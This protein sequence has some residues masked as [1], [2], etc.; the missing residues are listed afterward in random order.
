M[1]GHCIDIGREYTDVWR[2]RRV[3]ES[4]PCPPLGAW[5][6]CLICL[7]A[8]SPALPLLLPRLLVAKR[9]QFCARL[10]LLAGRNTRGSFLYVTGSRGWGSF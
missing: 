7:P 4:W 5:W 8:R 6:E 9:I 1:K 3:R 10:L 2:F